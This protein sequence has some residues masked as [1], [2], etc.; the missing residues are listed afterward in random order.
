MD[1]RIELR[2][3]FNP[4]DFQ[5]PLDFPFKFLAAKRFKFY[6]PSEA[7]DVEEN[8]WV[9]DTPWSWDITPR[10]VELSCWDFFP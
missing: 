4:A 6:F 1:G 8:L 9:L 3:A 5:R 10:K 2:K 7:E